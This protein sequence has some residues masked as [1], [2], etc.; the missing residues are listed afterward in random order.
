[1]GLAAC[2]VNRGA[3]DE[4]AQLLR[5]ALCLDLEPHQ[6]AA[7]LAELGQMNLEAGDDRAAA[8][9]LSQAVELD[10]ISPRTRLTYATS[11]GRIGYQ[12]EAEAER[13]AGRAL[14]EKQVEMTNIVRRIRRNPDNA[15]LRAEAG[16]MFV[17]LGMSREAVRWYETAIQIDPWH[18]VSRRALIRIADE[19]GNSQA[20]AEHSSFLS[21]TVSP[22]GEGEPSP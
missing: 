15:D 22:K 9:I 14:S 12:A 17:G 7:A 10:P 21:D 4:A 11:L 19:E 3:R 8:E 1:M 20:V 13:A 18:D 2:L 16:A 5:D 6:A